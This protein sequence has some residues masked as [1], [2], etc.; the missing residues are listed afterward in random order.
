MDMN[1]VKRNNLRNS[2]AVPLTRIRHAGG[3]KPLRG[4]LRQ[5]MPCHQRILNGTAPSNASA[6][7]SPLKKASVIDLKVCSHTNHW[8]A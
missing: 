7:S 3:R 5:S 4:M 6:L 1:P 2:T 8:T